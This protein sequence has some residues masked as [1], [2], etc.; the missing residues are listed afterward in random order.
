[1]ADLSLHQIELARLESGAV[2]GLLAAATAVSQV[3]PL[4]GLVSSW[5]LGELALVSYSVSS[6]L[7]PGNAGQCGSP[8]FSHP[9]HRLCGVLLAERTVSVK[10]LWHLHFLSSLD[11]HF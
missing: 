2:V 6:E 4:R 5:N 3:Q 1:M 7:L 9:F 11:L 10:L 8:A